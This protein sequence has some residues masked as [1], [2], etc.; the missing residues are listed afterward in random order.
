[1]SDE[2][3]NQMQSQIENTVTG[4]AR[5]YASLVL[6]HFEQLTSLQLETAKAY[7]E[8]GLQQARAA[9]EVKNSSDLQSYLANQQKVTT[10]LSERIKSDVEKVTSLNQAFA[11]NA[12]KVTQDSAG[13]V[14]KAAEENVNKMTQAQAAEKGTKNK[15]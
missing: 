6:D 13:E 9:L 15:A 7:A 12:Q 10:E 2:T 3:A 4:P 14:S 11:K 8:T 1:M 5:T